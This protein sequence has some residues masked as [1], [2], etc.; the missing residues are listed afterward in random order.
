M[1]TFDTI[2]RSGNSDRLVGAEFSSVVSA[3]TVTF[4]SRWDA[5]NPAPTTPGARPGY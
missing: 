1:R 5:Q 2:D 3:T 4:A